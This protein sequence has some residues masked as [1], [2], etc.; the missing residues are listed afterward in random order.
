MDSELCVANT[1]TSISAQRGSR[2][3]T[4]FLTAHGA[5]LAH[6]QSPSMRTLE[7]RIFRQKQKYFNGISFAS[8]FLEGN[9]LETFLP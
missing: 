6:T 4:R 5:G 3:T 2:R 1:G 9:V 8:D 7:L